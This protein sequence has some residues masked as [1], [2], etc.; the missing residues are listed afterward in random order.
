M[1]YKIAITG[2]PSTGKSTLLARLSRR[3]IPVFSADE[4]VHNLTNTHVEIRRRISNYFG[5]EIWLRNGDLDRKKLL[6]LIVQ[7]AQTREFLES[8][9]HPEVKRQLALF[10]NQ[11]KKAPVVAAEIPLLYEVGWESLFD[12]VVVVYVPLHIQQERLQKKIG[13]LSLV[14]AFLNLQWPLAEKCRRADIVAL[15]YDPF[16]QSSRSR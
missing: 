2:G 7:D 9:F 1:S 11:N 12:L 15:G 8:L 16:T 4:V 13:D 3:G 14:E 5:E 10:F 6:R